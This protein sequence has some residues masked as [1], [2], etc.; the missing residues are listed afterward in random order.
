MA[1]ENYFSFR[2][3]PKYK[4]KEQGRHKYEPGAYRETIG[5]SKLT[6]HCFL[7]SANQ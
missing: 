1:W 3:G 6:I 5:Y 4:L 7:I 2:Y